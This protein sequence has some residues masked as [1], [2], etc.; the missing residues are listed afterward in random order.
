MPDE[1]GC[2]DGFCPI[3]KPGPAKA[4]EDG[5]FFAPIEESKPEPSSVTEDSRLRQKFLQFCEDN[6]SDPE[7]KI[8]EV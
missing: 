5:I 7:C 1:N 4:P 8:H 2:V 6:P 3:S